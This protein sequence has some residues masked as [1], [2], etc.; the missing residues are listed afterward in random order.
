MVASE[1]RKNMVKVLVL[2]VKALRLK[3]DKCLEKITTLQ[4][5]ATKRGIDLTRASK[6]FRDLYLPPPPRDQSSVNQASDGVMS[7]SD[8]AE[9]VRLLLEHYGLCTLHRNRNSIVVV[10]IKLAGR[11]TFEVE[12]ARAKALGKWEMSHGILPNQRWAVDSEDFATSLQLLKSMEIRGYHARIEGAIAEYHHWRDER[13]KAGVAG[14]ESKGVLSKIKTARANVDKLVSELC[15]WTVVGTEDSPETVALSSDIV[16]KMF[17]EGEMPWDEDAEGSHLYLGRKFCFD[18]STRERCEE[19]LA[20]IPIETRRLANWLKD[21]LG[22]IESA[23]IESSPALSTSNPPESLLERH[24]VGALEG[25]KRGNLLR[26]ERDIKSVIDS[27]R[28]LEAIL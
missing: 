20:R 26:H 13:V 25:G 3:R 2:R 19:E 27:L 1:T 6:S 4:S 14:I 11:L 28:E 17:A 22:I 8:Q 12:D 21:S 18:D 7:E 24:I 5:I 16:D 10:S 23:L 9:Y 15:I